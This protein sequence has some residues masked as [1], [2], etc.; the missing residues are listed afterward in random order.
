MIRRGLDISHHQGVVNFAT[1][2]TREIEVLYIRTNYGLR[3]DVQAMENI[4]ASQHRIMLRG[5]Y[6]YW[7]PAQDAAAQAEKMKAVVDNANRPL[8]RKPGIDLEWNKV[9]G[10]GNH[11]K[12]VKGYLG[13]LWQLIDQ[14]ERLFISKPVLYSNVSHILNY[15]Q[16]PALAA[17]DLWLANWGNPYPRVPLPWFPGTQAGWQFNCVN[18]LGK[19][20]GCE[21][22]SIDLDVW[23]DDQG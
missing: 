18:K 5:P 20:F 14:V 16:D 23:Y 13:K 19:W 22:T 10:I 17:Y 8:E 9:D 7:L 21:S 12:N 4:R 11:P 3:E 1:M 2:A 6:V 15:L